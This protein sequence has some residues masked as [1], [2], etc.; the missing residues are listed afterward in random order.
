RP[1]VR[2]SLR[3]LVGSAAG[4]GGHSPEQN[5]FLNRDWSPV[6]QDRACPADST[7]GQYARATRSGAVHA[8]KKRALVPMRPPTELWCQGLVVGEQALPHVAPRPRPVG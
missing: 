1:P 2:R 3:R 6:W 7:F 8:P 4:G 5:R